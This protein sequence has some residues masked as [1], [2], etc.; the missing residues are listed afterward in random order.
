M[1]LFLA[2]IGG[3]YASV[4]TTSEL[5]AQITVQGGLEFLSQSQSSKIDSVRAELFLFPRT[6]S[7]QIVNSLT[8]KPQAQMSEVSVQYSWNKPENTMT[9]ELLA[10]VNTHEA[11]RVKTKEKYP[12]Q[13]IPEEIMQFLQPSKIITSTDSRIREQANSIASGTDD[14]FIVVTRLADWTKKNIAYNLSSLTAEVAQSASWVIEHKEGV[15]DELTSLFIAMLRSL[16]IPGRF[17]S[18]LSHSNSPLVPNN[19]GSHGWAEVWFPNTGWVSFDPTFGQYGWIDAGHIK[20]KEN[21]DPSEKSVQ[22][23]WQARDMQVKTKPLTMTGKVL[24][25]GRKKKSELAISIK[26]LHDQIGFGSA[27][28][29]QVQIKNLQNNYVASHIRLA[30]SLELSIEMPEQLAILAPQSETTLSWLVQ[31]NKGLQ[32]SFSYSIPLLAM[33]ELNETGNAMLF[34][35]ENLPVY[36][37]KEMKDEL[38]IEQP[39]KTLSCTISPAEIM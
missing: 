21:I 30:S 4:I 23:V 38:L 26:P 15:C 9:Y 2:I 22:F 34:V 18:G 25:E 37:K 14:L 13:E 1:L 8:T 12:I 3:A 29:I 6:S 27:N 5:T 35:A 24:Q 17:V 10:V 32:Q 33:S 11:E 7:S 36:T 31:V 39:S 20:L 16:G 19:W 28:V